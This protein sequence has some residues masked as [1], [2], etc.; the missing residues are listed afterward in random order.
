VRREAAPGG[1][2]AV[3]ERRTLTLEELA[4]CRPGPAELASATRRLRAKAALIV[5]L[6]VGAYL[7][8]V[9]GAHGPLVALPL[10]GVLVL[11]LAATGTGVMHDA[12]HG[13]FG[14]SKRLNRMLGYSA[15]LLGASSWLWRQKHNSIHHG[16]TNVEGVDTD[17]EQMPFARLAPSQEWRPWHRYQH[18]YMWPLYGFLTIQ[19]FLFS[20][21]ASLITRRIG[22]QPLRQEPRKRD[23][24]W[25]ITG[26]VLH[27]GWAFLLPLAFHRWW[28]VVAFYFAC[29][30]LVGFLLAL[31]FQLAH[32]V[33]R[34]AF[35]PADS[36]RR[37][38]AFPDHQLLTT[39]DVRL[40]TPLVGPPIAW[41]MGGLHH[42]IEHHLAPGVPHTAYR[43]MAARVEE[44]CLDKRVPYRVHPSFF[45]A[46]R[47]H[48]RWLY[49]MGHPVKAG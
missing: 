38:E 3:A 44:T 5:L 40:H 14:K 11:A 20:D 9:I 21:F 4:T 26:K 24:A 49:A 35:T 13:A 8:L 33:D 15:D 47:S 7:W 23:V 16:N 42:Q 39:A 1:A 32:C 45:A 22:S 41:L 6:A 48:T 30:W 10:A 27:F 18:I 34:V 28:T 36:P 19:W 46:V 37:G 43:A 31:F 12:N 2:T 25:L 29:S 17:I